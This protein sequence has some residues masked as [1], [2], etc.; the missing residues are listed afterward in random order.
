MALPS[1]RRGV[2]TIHY[3]GGSIVI[4]PSHSNI[5]R[6]ERELSMNFL[7]FLDALTSNPFLLV[8]FCFYL[9]AGTSYSKDEIRDWLLGN[10]DALNGPIYAVDEDGERIKDK[11]TGAYLL[12]KEAGELHEPIKKTIAYASGKI[13]EEQLTKVLEKKAE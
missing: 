8:E 4:L 5:A 13:Y 12:E 1:T 3:A 7:Q 2:S 9:Q 6:L 10:I 11:E